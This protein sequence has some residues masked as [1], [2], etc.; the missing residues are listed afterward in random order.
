MTTCG[1]WTEHCSSTGKKYYYNCKTEVS[2]WEKPKDWT[3]VEKSRSAA[4]QVAKL[5]CDKYAS[6]FAKPKD[7]TASSRRTV[8]L[9]AN[10]AP[11]AGSSDSSHEEKNRFVLSRTVQ[12]AC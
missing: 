6:H 5:H 9:T 4:G 2:Q 7:K 12:D 8:V 10:R 11:R 1:D 3:D